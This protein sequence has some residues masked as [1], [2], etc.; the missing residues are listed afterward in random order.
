MRYKI[1]YTCA[2]YHSYIA[3]QIYHDT[4]IITIILVFSVQFGSINYHTHRQE[5]SYYVL[6]TQV[7]NYFIAQ[8]I[9][10]N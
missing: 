4:I 2:A 10:A 3:H 8:G 1:F 5:Y 6:L 9:V 7:M